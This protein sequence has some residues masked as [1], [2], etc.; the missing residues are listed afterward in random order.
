MMYKFLKQRFK[1][2]VP[3]GIVGSTMAGILNSWEGDELS[4]GKSDI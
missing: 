4:C 3:R 1:L 2:V